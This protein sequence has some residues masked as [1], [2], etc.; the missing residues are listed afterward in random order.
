MHVSSVLNVNLLVKH[1]AAVVL[2]PDALEVGRA[3]P[4]SLSYI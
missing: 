3:H 4:A 2:C 1:A